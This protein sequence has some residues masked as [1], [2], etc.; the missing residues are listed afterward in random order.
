MDSKMKENEY[1]QENLNKLDWIELRNDMNQVMV[2]ETFREKF[3][4]KF[5]ENPLVPIG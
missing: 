3:K 5:S 4:R 2:Q 1:P